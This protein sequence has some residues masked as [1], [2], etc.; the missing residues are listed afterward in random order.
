MKKVK[1]K[2]RA[3]YNFDKIMDKGTF[4]LIMFLL[5]VTLLVSIIAGVILSSIQT[6]WSGGSLINSIWKSF[7]LT[8][9][10]GNQLAIEGNFRFVAITAIMT[11]CGI[12]FITTLIGIINSGITNKYDRLRQ[13]TS[14]V[15]ENKHTVILGFNDS[16]YRIISELIITNS[17]KTWREHKPCIVILGDEDISVMEQKVTNR[18]FSAIKN[19]SDENGEEICGVDKKS[20][21]KTKLIYRKG[22]PSIVDDL[23]KCSIETS[24]SV[25][26][27]EYDDSE[28]IKIL[29]AIS[30]ILEHHKAE[31]NEVFVVTAITNEDNKEV[32][33]LVGQRKTI[34][35]HEATHDQ[36]E[37]NFIEVLYFESIVSRIVAQTLFQPGLSQVYTELFNFSGNEIY[38]SPPEGAIG[39]KFSEILNMFENA[40]VIG[41][42]NET[43]TK[44]CPDMKYKISESDDLILIAEDK[45]AAIFDEHKVAQFSYKPISTEIEI[46]PN[47]GGILIFG[48]NRFLEKILS[49]LNQY[50]DENVPVKIIFQDEQSMLNANYLVG[51]FN[52]LDLS[53]EVCRT[54]FKN[55]FN[56]LFDNNYKHILVLSDL[57]CDTQKSDSGTL[58]LLM[59]LRDIK[60][61]KKYDFNITSQILDV[62]NRELAQVANVN[63]FVVSSD[64]VSLMLT[65]ISQNRD[66]TLVF[67]DLLDVEGSE[68][69]LK[70]ASLYVELDTLTSLGEIVCNAANRNEVF[71]GYKKYLSN[72][73]INPLKSERMTFKEED[74]II[75]ISEEGNWA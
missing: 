58:A 7:L 34:T 3:V 64:I 22:L 28:I 8:L 40:S 73:K 10:P 74:R 39:H 67:E 24:K 44:L 59:R 68:I 6:E 56:N 26:V 61:K 57:E 23:R 70:P 33:K 54:C 41:I 43:Q 11:F 5:V 31:S 16:V 71:I 29:L 20:K 53:N 63:D 32:A 21:K 19:K 46:K 35:I 25:I 2:E 30:K 12:A 13:G 9:D 42:K 17:N 4:A 72:S 62:K 69:Y 66:L 50:F 27:N 1:L 15:I 49:E 51:K 65:Q 48:Y 38:I 37:Y 52:K 60:E 75:V 18:I 36:D 14:K 55:N 47:N 45:N